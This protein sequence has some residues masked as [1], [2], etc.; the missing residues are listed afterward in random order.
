ML[1]KS[2]LDLLHDGVYMD[3]Q[4]GTSFPGVVDG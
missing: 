1:R 4:K 3:E 2:T